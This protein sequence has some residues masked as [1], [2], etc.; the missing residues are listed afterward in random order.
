MPKGTDPKKVMDAARLFARTEFRDHEYLLVLHEPSTDPKPNAPQHPHVHIVVRS[1]AHDG[2]QLRTFKSDLARW[3][4]TFA[5]QLREVGVPANATRKIERGRAD[6]RSKSK[7]LQERL[8]LPP[9]A[10]ETPTAPGPA[11]EAMSH[12]RRD[13]EQVIDLLSA[14]PE[15]ADQL[16]VRALKQ[17]VE[18]AFQSSS[19]HT[20]PDQGSR[21]TQPHDA[22]FPR[23]NVD[24]RTR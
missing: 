11:S 13:Y 15:P 19:Q 22:A 4:D 2:R 5:E 24:E 1:K 18:N 8:G 14:S 12:A 3:R 21:P 20:R 6:K 9:R 10:S 23:R 17:F 16:F 7:S